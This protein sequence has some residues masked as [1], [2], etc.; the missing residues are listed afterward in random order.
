MTTAHRPTYKAAVAREDQGHNRL[1]GRSQQISKHDH[2]H[3][4]TTKYRQKGQNREDELDRAELKKKLFEKE[5]AHFKKAG[6]DAPINNK[7]AITNAQEDDGDISGDDKEF[8][9]LDKDDT[10]SDQDSSEISG[11]EDS[12]DETAEL[13]RELEKIKKERAVEEEKKERER[14]AKE[15]KERNEAILMGNPLL[16]KDEPTMGSLKRRWDDDV[17]FKNQSRSEPT[18]K[19]KFVNDTIRSDFHRQFLKKY[20]V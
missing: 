8:A 17:V 1:L 16:G 12:D 14:L 13:M 18:K 3:H 11:G 4:L 10:D 7:E 5:A 2:P 6:R 9:N 19:K 20:I 15:E